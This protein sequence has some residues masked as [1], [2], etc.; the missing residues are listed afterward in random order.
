MLTMEARN[1]DDMHDVRS[2]AGSIAADQTQTMLRRRR[3]N[4][5]QKT[6]IPRTQTRLHRNRHQ[7]RRLLRESCE[8]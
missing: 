2:V 5:D 6:P 8:T 4:D 3:L 7:E 1:I